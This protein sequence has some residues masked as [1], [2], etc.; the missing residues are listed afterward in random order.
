MLS[1][2]PAQPAQQGGKIIGYVPLSAVEDVPLDGYLPVF[3]QAN[4][5]Q[6][7]QQERQPMTDELLVRAAAAAEVSAVGLE[8]S[9]FA[10]GYVSGFRRAERHHGIRKY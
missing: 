7:A 9:H 10:D 6:P 1:A 3:S 5:D 2:A 8:D 4:T